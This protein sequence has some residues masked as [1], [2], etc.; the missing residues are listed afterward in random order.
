MIRLRS[1]GVAL[2][3][4]R[5]AH[6][7]YPDSDEVPV[8]WVLRRLQPY[9]VDQ[10]VSE[11]GWGRT[12]QY[13]ASGSISVVWSWGRNGEQDVYPGGGAHAGY[14]VD[15]IFSNG[16]FW[17]G[18]DGVCCYDSPVDEPFAAVREAKMSR[19]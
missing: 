13:I 11:D 1:I 7:E 17:Q 12:I 10:L 16:E 8:S 14:D 19:E 15:L 5:A 9:A 6:G 2:E 18:H 3:A 4:Y